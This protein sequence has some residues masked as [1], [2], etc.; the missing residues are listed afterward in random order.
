MKA[1]VLSFAFFLYWTVLGAAFLHALYSRRNILRNLLLA[2]VTGA[3]LVLLCTFWINRLGIPVGRFGRPLTVGLFLGALALLWLS[4]RK[5]LIPWRKAAPFAVLL[6]VAFLLSASPMFEFGSNWLSYGNNDMANY[7]LAAHRF[8]DFGYFDVP[9]PDVF[10]E[11]RDATLHYWF[12]HVPDGYRSGSELTVSFAV[13]VTAIDGFRVFMPVIFALHL[14]MISAAAGL[15]LTSRKRRFT[16][17]LATA[18]MAACALLTLGV[19][20][21]LIAQVFGMGLLACG[22]AL[23]LRPFPRLSWR[24]TLEQA[25]VIAVNLTA[26]AVTY[27]EIVPFLVVAFLAWHGAALYRSRAWVKDALPIWGLALLLMCVLMNTYLHDSVN[28]LRE[29]STAD[30]RGYSRTET[31]FPFY[32]IPSGLANFWSLLG[33]AQRNTPTELNAKVAAGALL[34][35]LLIY[36]AV[37][38]TRRR[39]PVALIALVMLV[40]AAGLYA[41]T[42]NFGLY[43]LAM[44]I[45]PFLIGTVSLS[46]AR[47]N[48]WAGWAMAI[49]LVGF[50]LDTQHYY[51]DRSRGAHGGL[52]EVPGA[53]ATRLLDEARTLASAAP[54][55]RIDGDTFN[56]VVAKIQALYLRPRAMEFLCRDFFPQYRYSHFFTRYVPQKRGISDPQLGALANRLADYRLK[57]YKMTTFDMKA[58]GAEQNEF[59]WNPTARELPVSEPQYLLVSTGRQGFVN[60][61]RYPTDQGNFQLVPMSGVR[62]HLVFISSYLGQSYYMEDR[63]H[64][65][66]FQLEPDLAYPGH[67][68]S[69]TGRHIL[70]EVLNPSPGGRLLF[71]F[72]STWNADHDNSLPQAEIVGDRRFKLPLHGRGAARVVS[73]P[74]TPQHIGELD[75]I[76]LDMG[77]EGKTIDAPRAGLMRMYGADVLLDIRWITGFA[78]DISYI[79]E[80]EYNHMQS[81][82]GIWSFPDGLLPQDL[83]YSGVYED[84]WVSEDSTYTFTQTPDRRELVISGFIPRVADAKAPTEA[85]LTVDGEEASRRTFPLGDFEWRV[86]AIYKQ[87]RRQIGL[88]FSNLQH[89][90]GADGRPVSAKLRSIGFEGAALEREDIIT[91]EGPVTLGSGWYPG[92]KFGGQVFRWMNNDATFTTEIA[93]DVEMEPG[94]GISKLPAYV[95][96]VGADGTVLKKDL[97]GRETV[98]LANASTYRVHVANGGARINADPRILNLRVFR[99]A[100]AGSSGGPDIALNGVWLGQGWYDVE[101]QNG[102]RFRWANT[103][104]EFRL[105]SPG[106][107]RLEIEPGPSLGATDLALN[108]LDASGR[109]LKS[110]RVHGHQKLDLDLASAW[111]GAGLYRLS[112]DSARKPVPNDPRTLNFR[113][114]ELSLTK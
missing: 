76:D 33:I 55:A 46:L 36:L 4:R 71:D 107:V 20:Y 77:R 65:A 42:S 113:V 23:I 50:S 16:A 83:E 43:K 104:S 59:L 11:N 57:R 105:K 63:H 108:V 5:P 10:A 35:L 28:F 26:L 64:A 54:S 47:R 69:S 38:W 70:F 66:F 34:T 7:V 78:R 48:N 109:K 74:I 44:F 97:R 88:K 22:A 92:E 9:N 79:S 17:L 72:T 25:F 81:P 49:V 58:P 80:E 111:S 32:L 90:P 75:Y 53:S 95:E 94:P 112:V 1:A 41:K 39:E 15:I 56:V 19:I 98:R 18:L 93:S 73:P 84:G 114:W 86:P 87:G 31:L 96:I 61:R 52:L 60:R 91:K 13:A 100:A 3:S 67:T 8:L 24:R 82:T 21:Q 106:T 103:N 6:V 45:Q 99:I 85:V 30:S 37:R 2:P 68:M 12:M 110:I 101:T 40:V 27:P 29:Q 51:V 102:R 89:L 14:A 62:D